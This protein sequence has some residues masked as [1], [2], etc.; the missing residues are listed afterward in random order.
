M[1]P[2]L[3]LTFL[4]VRGSYPVPDRRMAAVGGN[5]ACL[6]LETERQ[7]VFLDAGTGIIAAGRR[8]CRKPPPQGKRL[9][10]FLTHLHIDH[11]MG[12]PFFAPLYDADYTVT[13][14]A[15]APGRRPLCDH[16]HSLFLPPFSPITVAGI[17]ARLE[18]RPLGT[19][20]VGRLRLDAD[21]SVDYLWND[22]HPRDGVT[23]YRFNHRGRRLV[24]ATDVEAT[25]ASAPSIV[26]FSRGA[27]ILIHDSQYQDR[28]YFDPRCSLRGFGHSPVSRAAANARAAGV[29]KL[30]L[31][32]FDPEYGDRQL[33][34]MLARARQTFKPSYLARE[35]QKINIRS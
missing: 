22:S 9:A 8:L 27:D 2:T 4:G 28:D 23:L 16:I 31:F 3:R 19:R 11:I 12:L 15:P 5:S 34:R 21:L 18:F 24:Y 32:H 17:K 7:L 30:F 6:Q 1:K 14:F 13:L 25:E 35:S 29:Q 33:Q 20:R 10:I 26:H